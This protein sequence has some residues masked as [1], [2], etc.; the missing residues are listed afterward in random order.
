MTRILAGQHGVV[1]A[2]MAARIHFYLMALKVLQT[3]AFLLYNTYNYNEVV[4]FET[5]A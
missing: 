1:F 5:M 2:A 3:Q 4:W